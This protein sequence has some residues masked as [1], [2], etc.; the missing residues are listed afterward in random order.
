MRVKGRLEA[1]TFNKK[2]K[3]KKGQSQLYAR[4]LGISLRSAI[5][6]VF[7]SIFF[8]CD[9]VAQPDFVDDNTI[10]YTHYHITTL[11]YILN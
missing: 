6:V 10:F 3:K 4:R 7:R 8:L 11:Y 2:Y 9:S 1:T 5:R